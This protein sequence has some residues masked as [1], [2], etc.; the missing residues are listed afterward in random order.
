MLRTRF[1]IDVFIFGG[2]LIAL[3]PHSTGTPLHEWLTLSAFSVLIV[4]FLFHWEWF[5]R[6]TTKFFQNLFHISR[7][8]YVLAIVVFVGFITIITS[9]LMISES[10]SPTIGLYLDAGRG[11]GKIHELAANLTLLAVALHFALHWDWIRNTFVKI[12]LDPL[13]G[14]KSQNVVQEATHD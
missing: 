6:T 1:W 7:L 9:G 13:F 5:L 2:F 3:E 8:N 10:V 11:W 14:R 4:H 12:I